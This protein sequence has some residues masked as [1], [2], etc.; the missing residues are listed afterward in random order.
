MPVEGV[1]GRGSRYK[2]SPPKEIL[3]FFFA[4]AREMIVRA[5]LNEEWSTSTYGRQGFAASS[6]TCMLAAT[7]DRGGVHGAGANSV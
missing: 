4:R 2:I 1:E 3:I 6:V 5:L 7:S